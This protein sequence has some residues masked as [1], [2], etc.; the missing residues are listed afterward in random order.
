[1]RLAPASSLLFALV[2]WTVVTT[3]VVCQIAGLSVSPAEVLQSMAICIGLGLAMAYYHYRGVQN[4]VLCLEA[5]L[6]LVGFSTAFSLLVYGAGTGGRPLADSLLQASD[7]TLGVSAGTVIA[8][9]NDR[10]WLAG[11]MKAAYFSAVPQLMLAIV[12]LGFSNQAVPLRRLLTRFILCG[13]VTV[14]CFYFAPALGTVSY[15]GVSVPTHYEGIL[16]DLAALRDGSMRFVTWKAVEGLITF[17][18]FHTIWGVLM[19]AAFRRTRLAVPATI[20]NVVMIASTITTGM[21]YATD[22][23]GGL[24]VCLIIFPISNKLVK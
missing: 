14:A 23:L 7:S 8:W 5:M 17:P 12:V 20:L 15:S 6:F 21:H 16:H 18:S 19:I 3:M 24:L 10:P 13:L 1:M 22:V 11:L 9:A 4:F 2:A